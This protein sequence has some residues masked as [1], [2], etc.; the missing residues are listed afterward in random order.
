MACPETKRVDDLQPGGLLRVDTL[1]IQWRQYGGKMFQS[2]GSITLSE[3]QDATNV[4]KGS[5]D[6]PSAAVVCDPIASPMS[7]V[8]VTEVA[9]VLAYRL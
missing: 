6:H 5:H 9:Y 7:S 8:A 2:C 1:Q 4:N 3:R